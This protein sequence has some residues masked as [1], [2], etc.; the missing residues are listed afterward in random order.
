[1]A[2]TFEQQKRRLEARAIGFWSFVWRTGFLRFSIPI[3]LLI[4]LMRN[5]HHPEATAA[6]TIA[7]FISG[8]IV[9]GYLTGLVA[10]W[11]V[12]NIGD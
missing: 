11:R 2:T 4:T 5:Q 7:G 6:E 1:M 8:A 12:N 3:A 10:W 9:C